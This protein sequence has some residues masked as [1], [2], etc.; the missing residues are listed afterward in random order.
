MGDQVTISVTLNGNA[1]MVQC[2]HRSLL[3]QVIREE[4]GAT[5]TRIGCLTGDCGA[6]TIF[7]DGLLVKS[8][9]ELAVAADG[10]EIITIEGCVGELANRVQNAFVEE[11]GFQCGFCTSG[12]VLVAIDLL[13]SNSN[14]SE[15]EIREALIGNLCRCTGYESIVSAIDRAA[16]SGSDDA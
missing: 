10:S 13:T 4:L 16:R 6:C 8:C 2:D 15:P 12:M 3:V 11:Y 1:R 5:G 9:L 14:P 7:K